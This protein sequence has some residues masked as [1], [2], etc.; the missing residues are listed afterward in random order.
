MTYTQKQ[1]GPT[2]V[3]KFFDPQNVK[4][5]AVKTLV[6]RAAHEAA[7][8]EYGAGVAELVETLQTSDAIYALN[9]IVNGREDY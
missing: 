3:R 4:V 2:W 7:R 8:N 9:K 1:M 5:D 6:A